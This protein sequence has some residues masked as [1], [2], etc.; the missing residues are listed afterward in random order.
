MQAAGW[1]RPRS[2]A[3]VGSPDL[4]KQGEQMFANWEG[5]SG[6]KHNLLPRF[7]EGVTFSWMALPACTVLL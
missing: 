4:C 1:G 6:K 3:A 5:P 7:Q 2:A